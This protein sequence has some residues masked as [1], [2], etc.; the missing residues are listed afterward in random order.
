MKAQAGLNLLR[1]PRSRGQVLGS[2]VR[3]AL[4]GAL[5]GLACLGLDALWQAEQLQALQ[6]RHAQ[7]QA[8]LRAQT[9]RQQAA[10][11]H[12][13]Q[14]RLATRQAEREQQWQSRREQV[15]QVQQTLQT[16]ALAHGL[17]LQR[18]QVD[19][20]QLVLHLWLPGVHALSGLTAAMTQAGPSAWTVQSL[21]AHASGG[22]EAVIEAAW[23]AS[24][25]AAG[26]A[27][28]P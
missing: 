7:L 5:I 8:A 21:S 14:Q 3:P 9:A 2:K 13:L 4:A 23:P 10:T 20:R 6:L 19:G 17:R 27:A 15:A 1:H 11:G 18:W 25:T 28:R 16:H 22:A 12:Q 24:P 26:K